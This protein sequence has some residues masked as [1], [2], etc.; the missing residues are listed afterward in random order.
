MLERSC[1]ILLHP[2]CLPSRF[3]IGDLGGEVDRFLDWLQR[4]GQTW[5]QVLPLG[6]PEG[7][8]SPY[9]CLSAFA[10]NPLLISLE[11]L[12]DDGLLTSWDLE[13]TPSPAGDVDFSAVAAG[14]LPCLK[15]AW[16][17]FKEQSPVELAE[18]LAT[19]EAAPEQ[20]WLAE[21]SLF[22]ALRDRHQGRG[23]WD[24]PAGEAQRDPEVLAAARGDLAGEVAYHSFVQFLFFR[25][26][27]RVREAARNRG[28]RI[29]GDLPIYVSWNSAEVWSRPDLFDLNEAGH[30][31]SVAGVPPD[32][33]SETGQLWGNPIYRWDRM[34]EDGYTWWCQRLA[35]NLRLADLVRLDHFRGFASF[36]KVP[37]G[38]ETAIN[39]EWVP[40]PRRALFEALAQNLEGELPL[41]AEDLGEITPDVEELL[42]E[43]GLPGMGVLQ[44]G[45]DD[46]EGTHAVHN[47]SP[48][49]VVYTGT[50][51]NDT[52][53][54]WYQSLD[55]E[56]QDRVR[57]YCGSFSAD[58]IHL[59]L[60]RS[61][62]NSVAK[63]A[64]VPL[65][66]VL[67]LD[68]S[69]RMNTPAKPEGNWAWRLSRSPL[70]DDPA[71][72][73]RRFALLSGRFKENTES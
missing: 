53:Q 72:K 12:V 20:S 42:A 34:H 64:I 57:D 66:D 3:G 40:G 30:P 7:Q 39:G 11:L 54:G 65:Q 71:L 43:L 32:Y 28:I 47:L 59:D 41:V 1:G 55:S 33:F 9:A 58:H 61:A 45:F 56:A 26:W 6:P 16:E 51:D 23:W 15:R 46:P 36:W 70:P 68:T 62:Y 31:R 38:E 37:A 69:A 22:A 18:A 73:L 63:L 52:T 24:W 49:S 44:F 60:I 8:G 14:K 29:L 27:G 17:R 13:N 2:T 21:W 67:G 5:W 50:H 35:A 4:A 19:F 25:Q 10:G 48:H